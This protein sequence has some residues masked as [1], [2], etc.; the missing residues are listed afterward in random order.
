MRPDTQRLDRSGAGDLNG[1]DRYAI[2]EALR[3]KE[4]TSETEVVVVSM[5]PQSAVESLRVGLALGADRAVLVSDAAIEGSDLVATG[6]VLAK[7]LE[8]ESPDLVLFGQQTRDGGGSLLWATVADLLRWPFASQ[9][10]KLTMGDGLVQVARQTEFGDEVIEVRLPALVAVSESINEP[11]YTSL[12]GMM[13]AKKKPLATLSL[14]DLGIGPH[15]TGSDGS[16]TTVLSTGA[17]PTRA[18]VTKIEDDGNAAQS[19]FDF[20]VERDLV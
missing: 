1:V 16:R 8:R 3:I 9:A 15:E 12:K 4:S 20:L 6:R 18:N 7:A 14:G 11:R 13:G 19:I 17:P 10:A 5:G 2:E